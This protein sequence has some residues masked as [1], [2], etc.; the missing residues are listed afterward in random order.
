MEMKITTFTTKKVGYYSWDEPQE[1]ALCE[2]GGKV[3]NWKTILNGFKNAAGYQGKNSETCFFAKDTPYGTGWFVWPDRVQNIVQWAESSG[4][5]NDVSVDEDTTTK[6][7]GSSDEDE[8]FDDFF[9][10]VDPEDEV[11]RFFAIF[12]NGALPKS[13]K[14]KIVKSVYK[15]LAVA[16]HPDKGGDAALMAN[17]NTTYKELIDSM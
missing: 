2:F 14:V 9:S 12:R 17:V 15:Q 7:D 6:T 3:K 1:L 10:A 4:Y 8:G 16:L 11:D 5:F 13:V